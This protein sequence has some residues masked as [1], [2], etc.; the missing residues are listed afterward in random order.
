MG[1]IRPLRL[2]L[3][4]SAG[5]SFRGFIALLGWL[6]MVPAMILPLVMACF[7]NNKGLG[8]AET[9]LM[10]TH[11]LFLIWAHSDNRFLLLPPGQEPAVL[12]AGSLIGHS[13]TEEEV[14]QTFQAV[15]F[16]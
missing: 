1:V 12:N 9:V 5:R 10:A 14:R 7:P 3:Y 6:L 2:S 13:L 4:Y 16:A 15:P 11:V 8:I